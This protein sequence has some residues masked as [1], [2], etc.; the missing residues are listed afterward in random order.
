MEK[1]INL[2]EIF[3][4]NFDCYTTGLVNWKEVNEPVLSKNKFKE[5][6]LE[7]GKKLLELAS[8]NAEVDVE[9]CMGQRTGGVSVNTE[10]IIDTIKQVE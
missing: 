5:L 4:N 3:N 7:F 2:E 10:S 6:F 9:M 8:E 1:K